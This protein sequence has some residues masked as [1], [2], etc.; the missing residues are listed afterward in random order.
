MHLYANTYIKNY[1]ILV[2]D[3]TII[4]QPVINYE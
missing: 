2:N 3:S 4:I 1:W